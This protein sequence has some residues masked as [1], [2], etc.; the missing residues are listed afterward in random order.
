[1]RY[2][3]WRTQLRPTRTWV[4]VADGGRGRILCNSGP[5]KGLEAMAGLVF[6]GDHTPS[7][8]IMADRPGRTFESIG[9]ARHAKEYVTDPHQHRKKEFV[10]ELCEVLVN[11]DSEFDRL[12]LVAPPEA[13]GLFRKSLPSQLRRKVVRELGKDLTHISNTELPGHLSE[14]LAL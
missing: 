11:N 3:I 2:E 8:D 4:V 9:A 10:T 6:E 1:M 13:L 7:R 5:G 14:V 12:V